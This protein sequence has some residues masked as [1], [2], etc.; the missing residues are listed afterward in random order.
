MG[1]QN[2]TH[3]T[4]A[5]YQKEKYHRLEHCQSCVAAHAEYMRQYRLRKAI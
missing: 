2:M 4:E 1:L 3:G 5:G